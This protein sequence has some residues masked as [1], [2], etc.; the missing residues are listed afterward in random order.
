MLILGS[1]LTRSRSA[2]S[3][4]IR[5]KRWLSGAATGVGEMVYVSSCAAAGPASAV[6]ASKS[7][8]TR[9][10]TYRDIKSLQRSGGISLPPQTLIGK[11]GR[12]ALAN[13]RNEGQACA[14]D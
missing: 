11:H 10:S 7:A 12:Q 4:T 1:P 6:I 2:W 3:S 14:Q 8:K 9:G 5:T 13:A